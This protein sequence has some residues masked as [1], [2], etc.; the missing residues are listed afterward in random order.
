M[1]VVIQN[2]NIWKIHLI[3]K[4]WVA[5]IYNNSYTAVN[6]QPNHQQRNQLSY[7]IVFGLKGFLKPMALGHKSPQ[8]NLTSLKIGRREI[9]CTHK[10]GSAHRLTINHLSSNNINSRILVL[11]IQT[12]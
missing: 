4:I 12:L 3:R 11:K 10:I 8:R 9:Q 1:I 7:R 5:G 2:K 6:Q